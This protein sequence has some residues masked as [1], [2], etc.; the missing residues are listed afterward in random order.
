MAAEIS[1]IDRSS[2]RVSTIP[3]T[4]VAIESEDYTILLHCGQII[5]KKVRRVRPTTWLPEACL[6]SRD[7]Q[8]VGSF[9]GD[10]KRL[11][12]RNCHDIHDAA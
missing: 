2:A 12:L 11:E 7:I 6:N 5:Y 3:E 8:P 10:C 4:A 9:S 1:D